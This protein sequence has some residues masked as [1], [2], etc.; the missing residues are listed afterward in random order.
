MD[1]HLLD[2]AFAKVRRAESHINDLK[3]AVRAFLNT[4]PYRLVSQVNPE[5]TE[6]VW[7]FAIDPI[8]EDIECFAAD[9]LHNLRTPLDKI[10]TAGFPVSEIHQRE[11]ILRRIQFP[12]ADTSDKLNRSLANLES[13]LTSDVISFL[14]DLEPYQGGAGDVLWAISTLDNWDKHHALLQ[15]VRPSVTSME[16]GQIIGT[17]GRLLRMGSQRGKHMV[18][19]PDAR[20]G[21]WHMH[22]P[23]EALRPI[24]RMKPASTETYL[25]YT[26][27]Y[28]D[29]E[30][31]TTTP[32]AQLHANIRPVLSIA[33]KE[34]AG[35][36]GIPV[37]KAL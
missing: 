28:D 12:V 27:P 30:I 4:N 3:A 34:L 21:A 32:G 1:R 13:H 35:W 15:P 29:M 18:P 20:P 37:L 11:A 22:Q 17:C 24:L 2:P 9:A 7:S 36:E 26:A 8:P 23:V 5:A 33:F 14:R 31:L 16:F 6:E 10:L 19:V 25:E